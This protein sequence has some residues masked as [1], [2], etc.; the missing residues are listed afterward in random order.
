VPNSATLYQMARQIEPSRAA[1]PSLAKRG[2][3]LVVLLAVAYLVIHAVIGIA[4]AIFWIVAVVA[5]VAA[6]LWAAKTLF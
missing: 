5:V 2:V 6:A 1:K 4:I 3:A